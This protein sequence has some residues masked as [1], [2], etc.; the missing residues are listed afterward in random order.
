MYGGFTKKVVIGSFMI[1]IG[2]IEFSKKKTRFCLDNAVF[3]WGE[4]VVVMLSTV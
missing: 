1:D 3:F 4:V 2:P